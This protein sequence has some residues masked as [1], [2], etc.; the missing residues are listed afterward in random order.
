MA[1]LT[2]LQQ[3]LIWTF[4]VGMALIMVGGALIAGST[5]AAEDDEDHSLDRYG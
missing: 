2:E 3:M 1:E 5:L 4:S